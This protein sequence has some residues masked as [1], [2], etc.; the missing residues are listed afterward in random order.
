LHY[1]ILIVKHNLLF[2]FG[3]FISRRCDSLWLEC[4]N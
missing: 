3:F 1:I 4:L 2:R